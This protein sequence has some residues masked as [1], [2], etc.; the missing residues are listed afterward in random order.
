VGTEAVVFHNAAPVGVDHLFTGAFLP[1]TV[2]P[3]IFIGEASAR[4]AQ[5][6]QLDGFERLNDVVAHAIGVRDRGILSHIDTVI[7]ASA[8][9]LGEMAVNVFID[10]G[11]FTLTFIK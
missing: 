4:P 5:N 7:D 3:V 9:M 10:F 1:D 11:L 2:F 6:R 8:Q